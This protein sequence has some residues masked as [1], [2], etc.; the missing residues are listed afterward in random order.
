[1]KSLRLLVMLI[2]VLHQETSA[3]ALSD[4]R[5]KQ[6]RSDLQAKVEKGELA[7]VA[8]GVIKTGRTLWKE[9]FGW[10]D[11]E[12][13]I[14]ATSKTVYP[15]AS[16]SKSITATG[17]WL[18]VERGKVK[19]EDAVEKRLKSASLTYYQGKPGD[20]KI[21][22]LLNMEGGI[23]HQFEYFYDQDRKE[24]PSLPEQIRRYGFVAFPPGKLHHYSNF[25]MAILDQIIADVSGKSFA[26]F[27][28]GAVFNPLGMSQTFV[29]RPASKL[30][31]RGSDTKGN[32]VLPNVFQPRGGAGMY[33][34]LDDLLQYGLGHLSRKKIFSGETLVRI[35]RLNPD[36]P[37]PYY[38]SGWGVLPTSDGRTSLLSNG[39]IAGT[40]TTLLLVPDEELVIVCLTNTTVGNGFTDGVAFQIAGALLEGYAESLGKLMEKVEP[41]FAQ[42]PFALD[43]SFIGDWQGQ[44]KTDQ[45][46]FP[47]QLQFRS[48]GAIFVLFN[49]QDKV[50]LKGVN[51]ES[52]LL[53]GKFTGA[54]STKEALKF[55][56]QIALELMKDGNR[57]FGVATAQSNAPRFYLP[58][59]V[60]LVKE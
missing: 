57:L 1:M 52:G 7:S 24:I 38:S 39:A 54:L 4:E 13:Q 33:S 10:A 19:T 22:H 6:I 16:L 46:N 51:L 55:P 58:Y 43:G 3:Q 27:M 37:N 9:A 40:A 59:Y 36:A 48:D 28:N 30:L 2:L 8:I 5:L 11:R 45:G 23:P 31:A 41:L 60:E 53:T 18:L 25:S 56:H 20:L 21:K 42:K 47:I 17:L 26:D 32:P 35:H 14:R 49:K 29:E 44:I 15:L 50:R 12:Q 34:T